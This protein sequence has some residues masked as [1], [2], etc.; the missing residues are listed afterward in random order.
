M[1][2]VHEN[3]AWNLLLR[4]RCSAG[5]ARAVRDADGSARQLMPPICRKEFV[6]PAKSSLPKFS[7]MFGR[8]CVSG[9]VIIP[10]CPAMARNTGR[11]RQRLDIEMS[12]RKSN[13]KSCQRHD[14]TLTIY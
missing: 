1:D 7:R 10:S 12:E 6:E 9:V 13:A 3:A 8:N 11:Q 2:E 4:C 5:A 14:L